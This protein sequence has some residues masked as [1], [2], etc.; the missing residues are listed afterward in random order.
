MDR[1][2]EFDFRINDAQFVE[3]IKKM[4]NMVEVL[5]NKIK[6]LNNPAASSASSNNFKTSAIAAGVA[7][8][9]AAYDIIKRGAGLIVSGTKDI[10]EQ[11]LKA[12]KIQAQY[13]VLTK[14]N[15]D[16]LYKDVTDYVRKTVFG[17]ELYKEATTMLGY[18][19][20]QAQIMPLMR[21]FGDISMGDT[22]KFHGLAYAFSQIQSFGKLRGQE[23]MQ[24][25]NAGMPLEELAKGM[26]LT[27]K[28][29]DAYQKEGKI[30]AKMVADSIKKMTEPGGL[31]YN[32][33]ETIRN[34]PYGRMAELGGNVD[35]FKQQLG[36]KII[37]TKG[38]NNFMDSIDK[39]VNKSPKFMNKLTE[40]FDK[41]FNQLSILI[42]RF[43]NWVESGGLDKVING[44]NL[45]AD[46]LDIIIG[47]LAGIKAL[48]IGKNLLGGISASGILPVAV[49]EIAAPVITALAVAFGL[50]KGADYL[51]DENYD[52]KGNYIR[53]PLGKIGERLSNFYNYGEFTAQSE[54]ERKTNE[55]NYNRFEKAK[56]LL[57]GA[58]SA[59]KGGFES[60]AYPALNPSNVSGLLLNDEIRKDKTS[61]AVYNAIM[62][63]RRR[64][65]IDYS[66]IPDI[67]SNENIIKTAAEG[68]DLIKPID[69]L[70][71]ELT[72][73][74]TNVKTT[75]GT[76]DKKDVDIMS[77]QVKGI[78]PKNFYITIN[79][80]L[81][82]DFKNIF[83]T[84]PTDKQYID[85]IVPKVAEA[86]VETL[87]VSQRMSK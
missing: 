64:T 84:T 45:L 14:G 40:F 31:F 55:D 16:K 47:S 10:V 87:H 44:F 8:G 51:A 49:S 23:R 19:I 72:K 78:Q 50:K 7:F 82:H 5:E 25:V 37:K 75:G 48:N 3:R 71:Q 11:G 61:I 63:N 77:A 57:I 41:G 70:I 28:Q 38:F 79:G 58:A 26:G 83:E 62:N 12:T 20:K 2:L 9:N 68:K 42:N 4:Q 18:G 36:E 17:P 43:G 13:N 85:K 54:S 74:K 65:G 73:N 24:L 30:S 52:R 39:L 34:T 33:M 6:S 81:I 67:L 53:G 22:E 1:N 69:D 80:G 32:M 21:Q 35:L 86:I 59:Y 27:V 56:T 60:G 66:I 76:A 29:M 15:G 46:N